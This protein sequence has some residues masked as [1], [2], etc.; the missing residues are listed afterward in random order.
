M[1]E[2]AQI[3]KDSLE[4]QKGF[5]DGFSEGRTHATNLLAEII[6][7]LPP[8]PIKM[9]AKDY[10]KIKVVLTG[11]KNEKQGEKEKASEEKKA[12]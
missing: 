11:G 6:S 4:Y 7:V 1:M 9:S 3:K 2:Q 5:H 12:G 10:E 8:A